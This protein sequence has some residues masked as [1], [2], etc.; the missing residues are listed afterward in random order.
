LSLIFLLI[1]NPTLVE[2][3]FVFGIIHQEK[4]DVFDPDGLTLLGITPDDGKIVGSV[5]LERLEAFTELAE[6]ISGEKPI[7][8]DTATIAQAAVELK[9]RLV[10]TLQSSSSLSALTNLTIQ[11]RSDHELLSGALRI[12]MQNQDMQHC[13]I[14]LERDG[15]LVNAAGL[16]WAE[17]NAGTSDKPETPPAA[18][19]FKTGEG[20]I[21]LAAQ[22]GEI[23]HCRDCSLDPR[24]KRLD[25]ASDY[26]PGS[27][28]S[29]PIIFQEQIRA[30]SCGQGEQRRRITAS[31]G[32]TCYT[33]S[34]DMPI[35]TPEQ[36]I[37]EA[38]SALYRAK[39]SG[40]DRISVH[41]ADDPK[42]P[43]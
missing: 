22:M 2:F 9:D 20:L 38:D 16:S 12:L 23:Q 21:G 43:S 18:H 30:L 11:N 41:V 8:C 33:K 34:A 39:R 27:L 37:H 35:K 28:I 13:S 40:K 42:K 1:N 5:C 7:F 17:L 6:L 14:F 29:M 3:P 25:S 32:L 10:D 26:Q 36:W 4:S 24:F 31:I 19:Q 15:Y